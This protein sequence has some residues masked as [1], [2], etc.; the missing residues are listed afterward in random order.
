LWGDASLCSG[1]LGRLAYFGSRCFCAVG[2]ATEL[3]SWGL[4]AIGVGRGVVV[5]SVV[6]TVF[7]FAKFTLVMGAGGP[8][9]RAE[10][11]MGVATSIRFLPPR[12]KTCLSVIPPLQ[13]FVGPPPWLCGA[14]LCG[15]KQVEC[16]R[17]PLPWLDGTMPYGTPVFC[18]PFHAAK[19]V[20]DISVLTYCFVVPPARPCEQ[21]G[22]VLPV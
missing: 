2:A 18:L 12:L 7:V 5:L 14:H 20:V 8:R 11:A 17:G 3:A 15:K 21:L 16:P 1:A 6:V 19:D 9:L 4:L 10:V 22:L 13:M